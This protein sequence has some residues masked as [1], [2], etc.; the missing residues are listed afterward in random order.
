MARRL[1][2]LKRMEHITGRWIRLTPNNIAALPNADG[3][4]EIAKHIA[5]GVLVDLLL[6]LMRGRDPAVQRK[7]GVLAWSLFGLVVALGRFAT[8]TLIAFAVQP[9][10]LVY[11]LLLPGF[12]VHAVFGTLS[13]MVTTPLVRAIADRERRTK[14]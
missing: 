1:L 10:S 2:S 4:F 3:V 12:I 11:A 6:P 9:P 13:G 5:P 8:V 7:R 14:I